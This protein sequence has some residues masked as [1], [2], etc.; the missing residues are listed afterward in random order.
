M[1]RFIV[2]EKRNDLHGDDYRFIRDGFHPFA[3]VLPLVWLL[4]N[5]QWLQ[6]AIIFAAMGLVAAAAH[7]L[8]PQAFPVISGLANFGIGLI[9]ALEGPAWIAADLERKGHAVRDVIFA[10]SVPE[11]EEIF[12]SRIPQ[13]TAAPKPAARGFQPVS[14]ASLIPLAG[15]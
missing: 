7:A 11:A 8:V 14:Q 1:K 4:W 15:A 13:V 9:T 3:L 6:A 10:G 2:V 12:A 5:R